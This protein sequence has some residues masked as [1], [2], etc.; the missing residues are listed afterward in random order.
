[1]REI[2]KKM[3][4]TVT[5]TND[6][7]ILLKTKLNTLTSNVFFEQ[8]TDDALYPHIVFSFRTIELGDLSRKDYI[9]EVDVW[10]KGT[11]STNVDELADKVEDLLQ[12]QNLPQTNILPT[13]YLI[14]RKSVLDP[15]KDIK[16]RLIRFQIQ[17]YVR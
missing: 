17:N 12:A 3:S 8:A 1:M 15:D 2:T 9:L 14:D 16:H 5:R 10:D 4:N 7:K 13:F 11:N 6:L